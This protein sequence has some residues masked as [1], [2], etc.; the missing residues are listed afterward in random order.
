MRNR[1]TFITAAIASTLLIAAGCAKTIDPASERG[2]IR[3]VAGSLLLNDDATKAGTL[4]TGFDNPG[5]DKFY[6]WGAKT[7]SSNRQAIFNGDEVTLQS[8][9]VWSYSPVRFWDSDASQYD[10]L[11]ISGPPSSAGIICNPSIPGHLNASVTYS[12]TLAQYDL[13]AAAYQRRDGSTT[14]VPMEFK[15]VLSAVSVV[16]YNDSPSITVTLNS[17]RFRNICTSATVNVEQ[18]VNGLANVGIGNWTNPGYSTSP[19][20]GSAGA[21]LVTGTH[22]PQTEIID[23]MVPAHLDV[24]EP[25]VPQLV[26]DYQYDA[27]DPL[28]PPAIIHHDVVTPIRLQ[29][30]KIRGSEECITEWLPGKKYNYE[31]HIRMGGGIIVNVS[32]TDWETVPAETP[33]LT[34]Q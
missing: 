2:S 21:E 23:L 29:D 7:V 20:L 6:V 14:P 8:L 27:E 17:Y 19:V 28:N 16:V 1:V 15:H 9:G 31:I 32:T 3:F 4:K 5:S 13:L 26:I 34:I 11:A 25:Y 24:V 33:G 30:I 10:F 12:S 22:F 18:G